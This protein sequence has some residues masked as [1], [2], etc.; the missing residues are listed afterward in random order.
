MRLQRS[1]QLQ[2][3][4]LLLRMPEEG[5]QDRRRPTAHPH[6]SGNSLDGVLTVNKCGALSPAPAKPAAQI[7][8]CTTIVTVLEVTPP[9]V[10]ATG[11]ELPAATPAGTRAFTW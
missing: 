4:T 1:T 2:L 3:T 11:T 9:I 6:P 8:Y 7:R 5:A 10:I